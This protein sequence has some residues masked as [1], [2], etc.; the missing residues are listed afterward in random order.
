M[1]RRPALTGA[2][3]ATLVALVWG[4]QFVVGKS[5]LG[6]VNAFPITTV[7]YFVAAAIWLVVL[8][9]VEGRRALNP[10]RD[11]V[12]LFW[13]GSLGFAGFNLLGFTGLAHARPQSAALIVALQPLMTAM[14]LWR[15]TG[16]RPSAVTFGFMTVALAGV[17]LVI[18]GGHPTT[19][20]TGSLGWG[21][22]LVFAAVL[23]F[24]FYGLGAA[25]VPHLS[26]LRYTTLTA[27]LGWFTIAAATL[28]ATLLGL[29]PAPSVHQLVDVSPQIAY[30]A[31]PGAVIAVLAWNMSIGL[32]GA[33]NAALFANLIPVTTFVI[34][35]VRGS[36]P[37]PVE[38]GGAVLTIAALVANNLVSRRASAADERRRVAAEERHLRQRRQQ[39]R[40]VAHA[41][42]G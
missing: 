1:T 20:V 35:I 26:A 10:G 22:A 12:R 39:A 38:I 27:A 9:L 42:V 41:N 29:V 7:R 32:I 40:A 14:I 28:T 6:T 18:S 30:L 11:T 31:L 21:D 16:K 3:L 37:N 23:S 15:R 5:A 25:S 24:T 34:E 13:L 33:R 2:L 19:I 4:G 36:R 8:A 17:A